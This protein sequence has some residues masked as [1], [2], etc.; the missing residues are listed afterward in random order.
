MKPALGLTPGTVEDGIRAIGASLLPIQ[1]P[2]IQEYS[3]LP[4]YPDH[5]DPFDRMLIAQALSEGLAVMT[6]DTR[7]EHYSACT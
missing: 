5:R 4:Q 3:R 6:A 7:F 2:H 1:F